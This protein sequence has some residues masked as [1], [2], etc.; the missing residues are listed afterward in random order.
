MWRMNCRDPGSREAWSEA[1]GVGQM[2]DGG[3]QGECVWGVEL[4]GCSYGLAVD[5]EEKRRVKVAP[6]RPGARCLI[7]LI[8]VPHSDAHLL[9]QTS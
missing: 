7:F 2:R 6:G 1:L 4:T 8:S 3:S 5:G 9:G